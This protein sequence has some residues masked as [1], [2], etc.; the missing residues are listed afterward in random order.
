MCAYSAYEKAPVV[1]P[2][3]TRDSSLGVFN[4]ESEEE[5]EIKEEKEE[6]LLYIS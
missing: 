5:E 1:G 4:I 6:E 3:G 2:L